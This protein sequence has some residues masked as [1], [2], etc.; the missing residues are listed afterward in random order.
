VP[1][2]S[3]GRLAAI[4][5]GAFIGPFG[6]GVVA[7]LIPQIGASLEAS[8]GAVAFAGLTAYLVPFAGLQLVSGTLGERMGRLRAVRMAYI[9]YVVASVIVALA[10]TIGLFAAGR[11]MQGAANAFMTSLLIATLADAVP[12]ERR[13]RAIG[14]F[15]AFTTAGLT[16]SPLVGGLA[17]AVDW[18]LAFVVTALVAL[19][20]AVVPLPRA[21]DSRRSGGASF[22]ALLTRRVAV[23]CAIGATAFL[24]VTSMAF[25]V[26]LRAVD[27][28]GLTSVERGLVVAG[29]GVAGMVSARPAGI[30]VDKLGPGGVGAAGGLLAAASVLACGLAGS[31]GTLAA[32]WALAGVGSVTMLAGAS[33]LTLSS[34][35]GN[36]GG[37][38]SL[39][40]AFRFS[41]QALAP[42]LWLPLYDGAPVAA[43]AAAAGTAVVSAG[44]LAVLGRAIHAR[45]ARAPLG[46]AAG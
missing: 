2:S 30:L 1:D 3:R 35:P 38:T 29:F 26:A 44:L 45:R 39:T 17:G 28:F 33:V 42:V 46:D 40:F 13:G 43:F 15:A 21:R 32:A 19:A 20:L 6:N 16:F 5:A 23:L 9:T 4:Y 8:R 36:V 34:V 37:A 41:G 24:G 12:L 27:A 31:A 14:T 7:V 25:L 11:A 22:R 18:R 10:P